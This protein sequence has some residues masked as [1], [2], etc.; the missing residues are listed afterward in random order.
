[1]KHV[2]GTI[3]L[4]TMLLSPSALAVS[5]KLKIDLHAQH[6]KGQETLHLKRMVKR[7]FGQDSL[8][9]I[10]LKKVEI[11]A[12][13]KKGHADVNLQVGFQETYPQTIDGTPETFDSDYSGFH[14]ISLHAPQ[15][16]RDQQ[17]PWKLHTK[18]NVK[19]DSI[20]LTTKMQLDY[21]PENV[22]NLQFAPKTKMKVNKVVGSSKKIQ[23]GPNFKAIQISAS[24]KSVSITEVKVKFSDG[25][26]VLLDELEGKVKGLK[27]F[28]F[29]QQLAKPID[30]IKVSA[31]SN[32]IFGSRGEIQI[33]T[34]KKNGQDRDQ[35]PDRGQRPRR[36]RRN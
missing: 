33:F 24:G 34:A 12:K 27:S 3:L 11:S 36:D 32:N 25:Q 28:K 10:K 17:G 30:F 29:K 21:N 26:V 4:S 19:L 13:S 23:V 22:S 8:V 18:G 20:E 5:Q 7:K 2:F 14:S 31:V 15:S 16:H 6:L 35:R 1:M 9:G